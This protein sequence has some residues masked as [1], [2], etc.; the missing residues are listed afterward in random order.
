MTSSAS[1]SNAPTT[2]TAIATVS[3]STIM[4]IGDSARTGTPRAAAISGS[5]V[6]NINGRHMIAS[7]AQY[8]DADARASRAAAGRRR[9]RSG[10]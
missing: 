1:T 5:T 4:K 7:A 6:A 8:D 2:C 3:P 10:R 9:P